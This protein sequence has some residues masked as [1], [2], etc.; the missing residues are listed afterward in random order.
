MK[1][2]LSVF[3]LRIE[4]LTQ[5]KRIG[6]HAPKFNL[7]AHQAISLAGYSLRADN[8]ADLVCFPDGRSAVYA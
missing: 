5:H 1:A 3:P 8:G 2:L 7:S 4:L 6:N